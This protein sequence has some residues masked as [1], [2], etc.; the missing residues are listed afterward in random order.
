M[1]TS[2]KPR[3]KTP[4]KKKAAE[5]VIA[6]VP[7]P[8]GVEGTM[9]GMF[10][11]RTEDPLDQ[12]Q[13]LMYEAWDSANPKQRIALAQ[14]ALKISPLC[15]D[16]YNLL[17]QEQARTLDEVLAYRQKAVEVGE[18]AL[19][20]DGFNKYA[21]HFW[22]FLETR[23][24]MRA[25]AG[26]GEALWAMGKKDAAIENYKEM[27]ELNPGDNQGIRYILAGK[28]LD[29]GKL[30]DLRILLEL[31]A[32]DFS[33]DIQYTRTLVAYSNDA[34]NAAEIAAGAYATNKHVPSMLSGEIPVVQVGNYITMGGE[35]EASGY[36]EV[37]GPAWRRTPGAIAWLKKVTGG[38]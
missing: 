28:L 38:L 10:G 2:K 12:A 34:G 1:P 23:P 31:H 35:D 27:L 14:K 32:E 37:F 29:M 7:G 22:G 21:G 30:D 11:S 9:A 26:L 17:A 18:E 16:A 20:P 8:R 33:A 13:E 15:A 6:F 24:Y 5:N 3:K 36:V 4:P 19:G 25:R